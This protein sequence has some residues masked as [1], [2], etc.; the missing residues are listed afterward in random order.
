MLHLRTSRI[1]IREKATLEREKERGPGGGRLGEIKDLIINYRFH[2]LNLEQLAKEIKLIEEE[3]DGIKGTD[4]SLDKI[5]NSEIIS[6]VEYLA[7]KI[8]EK[9]REYKYRELL[10]D[11]IDKAVEE[12]D[13][14]DKQ[15]IKMR[16]MDRNTF[17]LR[18]PKISMEIG[19]TE[20]QCRRRIQ[21]ALEK[22]AIS[23]NSIN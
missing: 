17:Y 21:K 10:L 15:L 1:K 4:Y 20:R 19:Y 23:L 6:N 18:W 5:Q 9:K 7:I 22:I 13:D 8:A 12:L 16:Y 11:T 2:R 3:I 14:I